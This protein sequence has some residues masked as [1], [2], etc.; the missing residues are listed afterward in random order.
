[1]KDF[2]II[3]VIDLM[4]GRAV[5][6]RGGRRAEYAPIS[7]VLCAGSDPASVA[8][9][10]LRV[11]GSNALYVADLDAIMGG[12]GQ[13][14]HIRRLADA[15]PGVAI[16]LDAGF[17]DPDDCKTWHDTTNVI[18][19]LGSE[20]LRPVAMV[21]AVDKIAA[22]SPGLTGGPILDWVARSS[23][24]T[25]QPVGETALDPGFRRG[26]DLDPDG[27]FIL[28]LDFD[29]NGFRGPPELLETPNL[30]P[31]TIIVMTLDR[32]GEDRG[33][34][35]DRLRDIIASAEGRR[36]IAAGG[37]RHRADLKALA[38]ASAAG[39]LIASALH[40]QRIGQKEIAAFRRRRRF[41]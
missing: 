10:L 16:L 1:M 7:S 3:P 13:A 31:G 17:R 2:D 27:D 30:W 26:D 19:V 18:P 29:A 35:L 12:T 20:S 33:P 38:E 6:A 40:D 14:S 22:T 8:H 28:S 24:A 34:D 21:T 32:V 25:S 11:T 39:V 9:A 5:A 15:L 4:R 36:V 41:R 37:V 23:R